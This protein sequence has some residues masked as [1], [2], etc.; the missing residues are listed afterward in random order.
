MLSRRVS[1]MNFSRLITRENFI[2]LGHILK[3]NI[4]LGSRLGL[5]GC[6][7]VYCYSRIPKFRRILLLPPSP[8]R[9]TTRHYNSEDLNLNLQYRENLKYHIG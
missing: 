2:I 8:Y 7:A 4:D 3:K 5:L 6:D 9:N 1:I